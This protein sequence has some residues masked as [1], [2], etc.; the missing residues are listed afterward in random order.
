MSNLQ[1]EILLKSIEYSPY[2]NCWSSTLWFTQHEEW[3]ILNKNIL[4]FVNSE[5]FPPLKHVFA[6]NEELCW[7]VQDSHQLEHELL[8]DDLKF[9]D[10][11]DRKFS[12]LQFK[13]FYNQLLKYFYIF[14]LEAFC[15]HSILSL[16]LQ[17]LSYL[18]AQIQSPFH[19]ELDYLFKNTIE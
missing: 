16:T 17:I 2:R 13:S 9:H 15:S 19:S 5:I 10:F 11:L 1:E 12:D 3:H 4:L 18:D 8:E 6:Q 7:R 14:Y